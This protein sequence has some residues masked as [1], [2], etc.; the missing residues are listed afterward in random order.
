[1]G[2]NRFSLVLAGKLVDDQPMH[3]P[4]TEIFYTTNSSIVI[5]CTNYLDSISTNVVL[6]TLC[7]P[8]LVIPRRQ[9]WSE[10]VGSLGLKL[11]SGFVWATV[12][13][14]AVELRILAAAMGNLMP[15]KGAAR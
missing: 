13:A 1:M 6:T 15:G 7:T 2:S 11:L 4:V 5:L 12:S 3:S 10:P 14:M 9:Q 8:T